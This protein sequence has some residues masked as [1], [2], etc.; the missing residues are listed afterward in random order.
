[1]KRIAVLLAV[2]V[3]LAACGTPVPIVD[4]Q[5]KDPVK[6]NRDLAAC[7][8]STSGTFAWGNPI[9]TCMKAKGYTLMGVY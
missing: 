3:S 5:G 8:A 1:M 2:V 6:T 7:Q 4:M 9:A